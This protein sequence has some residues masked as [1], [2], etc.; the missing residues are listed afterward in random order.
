MGYGT[1]IR[2]S[3]SMHQC[4]FS[5]CAHCFRTPLF[6]NKQ[7]QSTGGPTGS[8]L[9]QQSQHTLRRVIMDA[10]NAFESDLL[11]CIL[12]DVLCVIRYGVDACW[13]ACFRIASLQH[14]SCQPQEVL[15]HIHP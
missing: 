3:C 8:T 7:W 5:R 9:H 6:C 15:W 12:S 11:L 2:S 1:F 13:T 10:T 14:C 4:G